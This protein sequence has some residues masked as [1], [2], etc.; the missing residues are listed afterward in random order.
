MWILWT[1]RMHSAANQ[2][3]DKSQYLFELQVSLCVDELQDG[4]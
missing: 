1:R 4:N 2:E 3:G